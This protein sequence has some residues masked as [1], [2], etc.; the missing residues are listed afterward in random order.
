MRS[1]SVVAKRDAFNEARRP[2]MDKNAEEEEENHFLPVIAGAP[3]FDVPEEPYVDG[4]GHWVLT[5]NR[6]GEIGC[7]R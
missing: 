6:I 5:K 3:F 2:V 7:I 4:N 1:D